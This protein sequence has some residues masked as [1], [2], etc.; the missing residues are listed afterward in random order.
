MKRIIQYFRILLY[1]LLI[2][3]KAFWL[4]IKSKIY[5]DELIEEISDTTYINAEPYDSLFDSNITTEHV[6]VSK[7]LWDRIQTTLPARYRMPNPDNISQLNSM[8]SDSYDQ[9][10]SS[11]KP[12]PLTFVDS[13]IW[14]R[15]TGYLPKSYTLPHPHFEKLTQ[16]MNEKY[17]ESLFSLPFTNSKQIFVDNKFWE[18]I[19]NNLP[20]KYSLP[21]PTSEKLFKVMDAY[22][23]HTKNDAKSFEE[24]RTDEQIIEK[25]NNSLPLN[26]KIPDL[27]SFKN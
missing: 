16:T 19:K 9:L 4:K 17:Y 3:G 7:Q 11:P 24:I 25:I 21:N 20:N 5:S 6:L 10:F 18:P 14:N 23:D 8:R 12:S 22:T 1:S 13:V 26:Y 2:K 27:N 15:I